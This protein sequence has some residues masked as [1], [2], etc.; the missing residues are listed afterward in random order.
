MIR[1]SGVFNDDGAIIFKKEFYDNG[2]EMVCKNEEIIIHTTDWDNASNLIA[3]LNDNENKI[4]VQQIKIEALQLEK[5]ALESLNKE[6][7]TKLDEIDLILGRKMVV[8]I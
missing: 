1:Y 7:A 5:K 8:D 6:Q 3:L 4:N 2:R